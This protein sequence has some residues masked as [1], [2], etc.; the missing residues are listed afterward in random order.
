MACVSCRINGGK[1]ITYYELSSYSRKL[2]NRNLGDADIYFRYIQCAEAYL[3]YTGPDRDLQWFSRFISAEAAPGVINIKFKNYYE[4]LTVTVQTNSLPFDQVGSEFTVKGFTFRCTAN[5][6]FPEWSVTSKTMNSEMKVTAQDNL[7][8][9]YRWSGDGSE[10][11]ENPSLKA[12]YSFAAR[13]RWN[14]SDVLD[15]YKANLAVSKDYEVNIMK[16]GEIVDWVRYNSGSLK[17]SRKV[18]F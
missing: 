13:Y 3:A 15:I 7:G 8:M 16:D 5:D 2:I 14:Y 4:N 1:D 17:T 10:V 12:E 9:E 6:G 18:N 11:A